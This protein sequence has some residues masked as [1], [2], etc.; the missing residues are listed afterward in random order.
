[1]N[2]KIISALSEHAQHQGD[3][4]AFIGRNHDGSACVLTYRQL[5]EQVQKYAAYFQQHSAH[6]VAIYAE[7]SP[8]WLVAD[9]AAMYAGIPCIPVPKFFSQQQIDH[10]LSQTQADLLIHDQLLDGFSEAEGEKICGELA[11]GHRDLAAASSA[12][13]AILSENI[14]PGTVKI[15]FTSGSTGHPE[16]VCLSQKN[17][18]EVTLSL[19]E[20]IRSC[21]GLEKHL[22]MLPLSTLLENITG[23]YVPL[24]LGVTSVVPD[25]RSV[26]LSGSSQF[27]ALQ[28]MQT[29]LESRPDTMVL[30]PALLHALVTLSQHHAE[31]VSSLK[32]VAV[33]GAHVP[34]AVL[35][36]ARRAGI[37]AYEGY[38]LSECSSVVALNT[39][40]QDRPG[41]SGKVLPH[42]QVRIADDGEIWVKDGI[43]LGYLGQPFAQTWLATGDLGT[44]D[45]QG[46]LY[47][48]GRKKNQIITSFGRN[49]SPEWIEAE[50]Q[51]WEALRH[52]F[53]TGE[54]QDRLSAVLV[55]N[56]VQGAIEAVQA[57][58]E[59]LPDYAQ[60]CQL[61]F[62]KDSET[63]R[64]FLTAN[65]RPRRAVIEQQTQAWLNNPGLYR[66]T[67]AII[68]LNLTIETL[69]V[70]L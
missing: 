25:G 23:G 10:V 22:V 55:S 31:V 13:S 48:R 56:D 29:L 24:Y 11:I 45:G 40:Q 3:K 17:L 47:V 65:Q 46:Y 7:N 43:A 37:P 1:M 58:N 4:A 32:F 38:G 68:T 9:L 15:T 16:G 51:H 54:S 14:L 60:V 33:G 2:S 30:T 52:F 61:I 66:D 49:I 12:E 50:A 21:E 64:S 6:C 63:Y 53:V 8:A 36:Q 26:G 57:L 19:A 28:W 41:S 59:T 67:I 70:S 20:G 27:D 44:L 42:V 62:I 34:K 5:L 69:E 35:E 18:D 39:P